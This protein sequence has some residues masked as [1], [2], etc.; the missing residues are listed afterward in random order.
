M[1]LVVYK[2]LGLWAPK[3]MSMRLLILDRTVKRPVGTLSYIVVKVEFFIFLSNFIT[4]NCEVDFQALIILVQPFLATG[5]E[6]INMELRQIKFILDDKQV[7]FDMC[8]SM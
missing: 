6:F 2:K 1:S 8:H 5:R 3:T 4:L 7:F